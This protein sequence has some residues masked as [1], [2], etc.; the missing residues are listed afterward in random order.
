VIKLGFSSIVPIL[1]SISLKSEID[2]PPSLFESSTSL[3]IVFEALFSP[4]VVLD[5]MNLRGQCLQ[6]LDFMLKLSY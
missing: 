4:P 5:E 2:S 1:V 6:P 3:H